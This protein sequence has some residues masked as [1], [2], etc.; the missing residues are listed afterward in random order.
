MPVLND[1]QIEGEGPM[2]SLSTSTRRMFLTNGAAFVTAGTIGLTPSKSDAFLMLLLRFFGIGRLG[3]GSA[4]SVAGRTL[5]RGTA[6]VRPLLTRQTW[7]SYRQ[8]WQTA[9]WVLRAGRLLSTDGND[10]VAYDDA[11][12]YEYDVAH[13]PYYFETVGATLT[14]D[15]IDHYNRL[16]PESELVLTDQDQVWQA[17]TVPE[18]CVPPGG[19]TV[20]LALPGV[21]SGWSFTGLYTTPY[22]SIESNFLPS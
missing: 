13:Y 11:D 17:Y 1:V 14:M 20:R 21:P 8:N 16:M 5:V 18:I 19:R 6:P 3:A 10:Y 4:A 22:A 2:N 12:E 9:Q 7:N 15:N